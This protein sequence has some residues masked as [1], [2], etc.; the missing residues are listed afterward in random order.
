M[1][2]SRFTRKNILN[3]FKEGES[4]NEWIGIEAE[5]IGLRFPDGAAVPYTGKNGFLAVLGK[6]YEELGWKITVQDGGHIH[7]MKRGKTILDL[8]SDG[9]IELAGSPHASLHD[10][11]R[12]FRIH[13]H[14]IGEISD[15]FGISWLG[16][17]YNPYSSDAEIELISD[18]GGRRDQISQYIKEKKQDTN[19]EYYSDWSKGTAGIH[20]SLDY[21]S[22][23]DFGKKSKVLFL[24]APIMQAIFANSPF[25]NGEFSKK[26]NYR[27]FVTQE[28]MPKYAMDKKLF[29]SKFLYEDWLDFV[30][31]KPALFFERSSEEEKKWIYPQKTFGDFLKEG[32][33]VEN[34]IEFPTEE[35]F[36]MHMKSIWADVR[37][38]NTLEVRV[39]D[40]LPPSLVPS[41]PA[42]VKGLMYCENNLNELYEIVNNWSFEEF[43]EMKKQIPQNGLETVFRGEK[44]LDFA[45]KLLNMSENGL[46]RNRILDVHG[47]D[48][49]MYLKPIKKFIFIENCSP[50]HWLIKK[51]KGDWA[52]NFFPV[53][54]WSK[55]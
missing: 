22:E 12:E 19:N 51:W 13:Q 46:K 23:E 39:F 14:E 36:H 21:K 41:V 52:R 25:K 24:L 20:V 35:D 32:I 50:A 15:V 42:F 3:Y 2:N 17:G 55:Y 5:K 54:E 7:Q 37:M 31:E 45:K 43:E 49:S 8:E 11:V 38:R 40:S 6:M 33:D 47:N 9:R 28:G 34:N 18:N 16:I 48:E 44:V 26:I 53:F 10:V 27:M 29:Y 30:C 4:K 1:S